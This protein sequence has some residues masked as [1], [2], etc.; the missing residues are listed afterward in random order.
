MTFAPLLSFN[1]TDTHKKNININNKKDLFNCHIYPPL[2]IAL[3]GPYHKF[4]S[5]WKH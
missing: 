1:I 2:Q 4:W 3:Q 5:I